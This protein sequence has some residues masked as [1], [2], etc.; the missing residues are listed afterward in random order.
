[1]KFIEWLKK[2]IL[3]IVLEAFYIFFAVFDGYKVFTD[4]VSYTSMHESREP[5]YP[6]FLALFRL[7]FKEDFYLNV[8]VVVQGMLMALA[9]YVLCKYLVKEYELNEKYAYLF[10]LIY[11]LISLLN[12]FV[13]SKASMYMNGIMS[14]GLAYPLFLIFIRYL[15]EYL[16]HFDKKSFIKALALSFI[17]VSIRKQMYVSLALLL[18][19]VIYVNVVNKNIKKMFISLIVSLLVVAGGF[20]VFD[21][22]YISAL[23]GVNTTHTSDGRFLAAMIIYCSDREDGELIEDETVKT[24]YYDIWDTCNEKGYLKINGDNS[25]WSKRVD[26]YTSS[27]DNIQL[28]TM[29]LKMQDYVKQTIGYN[30]Q[31]EMII[32]GYLS[33]IINSLL[34]K[35]LPDL[36]GTVIDSFFA[37]L[38]ITV[39]AEN[40]IFGIYAII[41]YA[42]YIGLMIA[43]EKKRSVKVMHLSSLVLLSILG[44]VL[45]VSTMIFCQTRYTIYN[46]GLFYIALIIMFLNVRNKKV[47]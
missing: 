42:L 7:I 21:Y 47:Q 43:N 36:I 5:I 17:L 28:R 37:G 16:N 25:S 29:W 22:A 39:S 1:M 38:M 23:Y 2:N 14:E 6:L 41:I 24:L 10:S 3:L 44:N 33:I 12:R 27:I 18:I 8:V 9:I 20:K 13:A 19:S 15:L 46:M 30:I 40:F 26:H 31:M 11:I 35:V 4:T 32:D 34:I 45:L